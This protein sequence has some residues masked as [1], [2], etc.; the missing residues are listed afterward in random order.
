MRA[1]MTTNKHQRGGLEL[2]IVVALV[3]AALAALVL[4]QGAELREARNNLTVVEQRAAQAAQSLAIERQQ[5][6]L[7]NRAV[8]N[9]TNQLDAQQESASATLAA[10]SQALH[11]LPDV[12]LPGSVGRVLRNVTPAAAAPRAAAP[13]ARAGKAAP[14]A[15]PVERD[16][17]QADGDED[18]VSCAAVSE[19]GAKNIELVLKPNAVQLEAVQAFYEEQRVL[20]LLN[21][22]ELPR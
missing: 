3:V 7:A 18:S 14:Q 12:R 8:V 9:L 15:D 20:L 2:L 22:V 13:A 16:R 1:F 19:W 10:L 21:D 6:D 5:R 17:A 4:W 11:G